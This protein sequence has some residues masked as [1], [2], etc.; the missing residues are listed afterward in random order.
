MSTQPSAQ[1]N[2]TT[3]TETKSQTRP[4]QTP[5]V[6]NP[7]RLTSEEIN[8]LKTRHEDYTARIPVD[9]EGTGLPDDETATDDVDGYWD[10]EP[11]YLWMHDY[12]RGGYGRIWVARDQKKY[13]AHRISYELYVGSFPEQKPYLHHKCQNKWCVNPHHLTPVT[14][15]KNSRLA[16]KHGQLETPSKEAARRGGQNGTPSKIPHKKIDDE[17][18]AEIRRR[19]NTNDG[20]SQSDLAAEYNC[21]S[22]TIHRI[23]HNKR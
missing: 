19:Y 12:L 6:L 21:S 2:E 11:C 4:P 17:T 10:E 8:R 20:L 22:S 15:A 18:A 9:V 5:N 3:T 14:V 7:D 23:I 1:S 13:T 16:Y